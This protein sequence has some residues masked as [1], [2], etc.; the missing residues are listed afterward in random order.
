VAT[1]DGHLETVS[2]ELANKASLDDVRRALVQFK[3]EPQELRLPTAPTYPILVRDELDRPQPRLDRDVEGGMATVVGRLRTCSVLDYKLV[4]LGHN[5]IRG[6][7]GG[8]LL[9][10][11]LLA[12]KGLLNGGA[13]ESILAASHAR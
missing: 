13:E 11:E 10:A 12:A 6:A 1:R 4:L 5:T 7:A 8:T 3:G 9:N 2:V